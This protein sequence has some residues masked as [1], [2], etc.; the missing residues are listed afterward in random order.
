MSATQRFDVV[1]LGSGPGGYRAAVLAAARGLSV[2]IA[3][4]NHPSRA[5]G[6]GLAGESLDARR[7]L[8]QAAE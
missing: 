2:A 1:V 4:F 8:P 5:E 7:G 3:R 6:I